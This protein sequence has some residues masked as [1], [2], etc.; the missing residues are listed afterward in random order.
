MTLPDCII[1][2]GR[3]C[4][5]TSLYYWMK[6]HPDVFLPQERDYPF[7]IDK[8]VL[9]KTWSEVTIDP[10]TWERE[11]SLEDYARRF[12]AA[13]PNQRVGDKNADLLFWEPAHP[14]LARILPRARCI[15]LL[16]DPVKRAW[17]HYWHE[18][19]K[20]RET[21]SFPQALEAEEDR[22]ASDY[23]RFQ[24]SYRTR[25][26]YDRSLESFFRHMPEDNT[27]LLILEEVIQDPARH[28]AKIYSFLGLDPNKGLAQAGSKHHPNWV[29][30]PRAWTRWPLA[31]GLERRYV[32]WAEAKAET[33]A[34]SEPDI[35]LRTDRKRALLRRLLWPVRVSAGALSMPEDVRH[36][37]TR[38]FAPHTAAL[39]ER[40]GRRI[41]VWR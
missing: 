28:L 38:D 33:L 18:V 11:H 19:G 23:G 15:L 14:R 25:G 3:R 40:L 29:L 30:L 39:E 22:L 35:A 16:R 21:L 41:E 36:K 34:A 7:F 12:A 8:A 2:G 5:T 37:L 9:G 27:L 24:L 20:G 17:S 31:T 6:D 1:S 32:R 4:G 26:Q 13:G 10:Q